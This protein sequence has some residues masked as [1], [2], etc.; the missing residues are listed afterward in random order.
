M[1]EQKPHV[2]DAQHENKQEIALH[3]TSRILHD[4]LLSLLVLQ[5]LLF[6]FAC[7]HEMKDL[8]ALDGTSTSGN[9]ARVDGLG[10]KVC[11]DACKREPT[12]ALLWAQ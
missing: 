11:A 12:K 3:S 1:E 7:H 4:A 9:F 8:I 5:R 6:S 2:R 10:F